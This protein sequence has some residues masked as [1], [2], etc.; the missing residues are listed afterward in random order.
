MCVFFVGV[1]QL[2]ARFPLVDLAMSPLTKRCLFNV[3]DA[4]RLCYERDPDPPCVV[5]SDDD[6]VSSSVMSSRH[7]IIL[8]KQRRHPRLSLPETGAVFRGTVR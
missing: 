1:R 6:I 8:S 2:S 3:M 7:I 4:V 5:E